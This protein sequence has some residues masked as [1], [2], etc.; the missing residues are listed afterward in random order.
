MIFLKNFYSFRFSSKESIK[1]H[2][3]K[4]FFTLI[5]IFR[6]FTTRKSLIFNANSSLQQHKFCGKLLQQFFP[7]HDITSWISLTARLC[8]WSDGNFAHHP[9]R[10]NSMY[11]KLF[12]S[13]IVSY[14]TITKFPSVLYHN[15]AVRDIM[16]KEQVGNIYTDNSDHLGTLIKVENHNKT[17]SKNQGQK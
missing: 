9:K 17:K 4:Q 10:E 11:F 16:Q 12:L 15:L 5:S 3:F 2:F 14:H 13:E 1:F 7:Q 6:K 8:Q